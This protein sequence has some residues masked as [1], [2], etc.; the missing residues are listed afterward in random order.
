MDHSNHCM[1][2]VFCSVYNHKKYITQCLD[3]LVRQKT[4]F[5][6]EIIVKD[7]ASTDGTSDI[8]R[9]Y[10]EKYPEKIVPLI[11]EENHLQR[12]L[13]H[14]AFERAFN[15]MRGKYIA[16]CEGDDFWTDENKLQKQVDFME[17]HPEYSLCGHAAYYADEDGALIQGKYFRNKNHSGELTTEEIILSWSMATCSLLYRKECR[18]DVT[19]PFQGNCIN[20]DY[21]LMVYM[22]LKG[23]VYYLDELM[24]A[25]RISC[26]GSVTQKQRQNKDYYKKRRLE[27]V[28]MLDRLDDYSEK[29]YTDVITLRKRKSLFDLYLDLCDKDNLKQYGDIYKTVPVKTKVKYILCVYF[30][31][32]YSG[33]KRLYHRIKGVTYG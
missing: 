24:S 28:A 6:Y 23:K 3:S 22:A 13:G 16:M 25:Y 8:I 10:H 18:T 26:S 7:D 5:H 9:A 32:L 30:H 14:V 27:Y 15:M 20:S 11:L 19:F 17:S 12:G 4:T 33:S 1:V 21:A 2:S 31:P 29:K